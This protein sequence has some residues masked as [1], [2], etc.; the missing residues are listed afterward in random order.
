MIDAENASNFQKRN[1]ALKNI[2]NICPTILPAI[3][4]LYSNP[5][6]LLVN[7][8]SREVTTQGDPLAMPMFGL[9]TL[10]L[11]KLDNDNSLTQKWYAHDGNVVGNL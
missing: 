9:A 8:K 1:L 3:H 11:I 6:I 4:N 10:L 5:F 2:A 7:K